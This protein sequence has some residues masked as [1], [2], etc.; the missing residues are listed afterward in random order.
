MLKMFP[1]LLVMEYT[2]AMLAV[3]LLCKTPKRILLLGL[4]GGSLAKF[5]NHHYPQTHLDIVELRAEV[6]VIARDYFGLENRPGMKIYFEDAAEYLSRH[7]NREKYDLILVD[8]FEAE[9]LAISMQTKQVFNDCYESLGAYGVVAINTWR[10]QGSHYRKISNLIRRV[11]NGNA[12]YLGVP[13]KGNE[14]LFGVKEPDSELDIQAIRKQASV[15]RLKLG[16]SF[17][18]FA[19]NL[20]PFRSSWR[21]RFLGL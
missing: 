3:L 21:Q 17:D 6:G 1:L 4:G 12:L 19:E 15:L 11:F 13:D 20:T 14:I 18:Q 9:D 7:Q 10:R 16:L 5:I 8:T 2:Q